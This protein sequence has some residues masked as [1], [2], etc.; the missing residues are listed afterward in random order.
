VKVEVALVFQSNSIGVS[1]HFIH[2]QRVK[3]LECDCDPAICK[4]TVCTMVQIRRNFIRFTIGSTPLE[5][6]EQLKIRI[7]VMAKTTKK[8]AQATPLVDTT[9]DICQVMADEST[10]LAFVRSFSASMAE[11]DRKQFETMIHSCPFKVSWVFG[12]FF[13]RF[14]N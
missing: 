14:T 5:P 10:A 7:V 9:Q 3:K 6:A 4:G 13:L 11:N 1:I 12:R 2:F 8:N